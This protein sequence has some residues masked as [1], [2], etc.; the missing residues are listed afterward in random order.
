MLSLG[1]QSVDRAVVRAGSSLLAD[2]ARGQSMTS[3]PRPALLTAI[4]GDKARTMVHALH[5]AH[6][7]QEAAVAGFAIALALS[8]QRARDAPLLWVQD[9]QAMMESGRPYG[10]GLAGLGF[11]PARL[12][13]VAVK[14]AMNA[15]A[16][17]EMGLEEAGLAGVLVDLPRR[18]P[19]DMLRLGKRL[20]LRAQTREIPCFLL[21][22]GSV[23]IETSVATRW[24][25]QSADVFC[26]PRQNREIC[27]LPDLTTAFDLALTKNRA[28]KLGRFRVAWRSVASIACSESPSHAS[29]TFT[30]LAPTLSERV[31]TFDADRP[32]GASGGSDRRTVDTGL[33]W[34]TAA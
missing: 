5:P 6:P 21:H 17:A 30:D 31:A 12:V 25:V 3:T 34:P 10:L 2:P 20:S 19:F 11:D 27:S 22:A 28:G 23:A 9:R 13:V 18:L 29:H 1:S 33:P 8:L 14:G 4:G 24:S 26:P 15:F 32:A 16:A 7:G